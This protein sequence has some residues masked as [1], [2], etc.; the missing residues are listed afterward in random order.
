M[1]LNL[2]FGRVDDVEGLDSLRWE[3]QQKIR[4]YV[5]DSAAAAA[6][7]DTPVECGIEV[8]QASRAACKLCKQKIMKGEVGFLCK[9]F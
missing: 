2:P 5:E 9:F 3:D 4:K 7:A 1:I 8:A 6:V